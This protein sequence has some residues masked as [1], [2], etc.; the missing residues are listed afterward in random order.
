MP[1]KELFIDCLWKYA[2]DCLSEYQIEFS[3]KCPIIDHYQL[4]IF[5]TG[6]TIEIISKE[7]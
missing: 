3:K 5:L 1:G 7:Y 6:A 4:S 2:T